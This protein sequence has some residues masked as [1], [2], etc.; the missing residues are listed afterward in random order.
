MG[1]ISPS[2]ETKISKIKSAQKAHRK[3][4]AAF[5]LHVKPKFQ[6]SN[7][8]KKVHRKNGQHF[9]FMWNQN[10]KKNDWAQKTHRKKLA[11]FRLHVKPKFQKSIELKKLIGQ[12]LAAFRL[13]VKPKFQKSNAPP[14][15]LKQVRCLSWKPRFLDDD[16]DVFPP[17]CPAPAP[18]QGTDLWASGQCQGWERVGIRVGLVLGT[19]YP[20]L[21][22]PSPGTIFSGCAKGRGVEEGPTTLD[23]PRPLPR[24]ASSAP[25]APVARRAAP[26]E[27][28][29][30]GGNT[31]DQP[32]TQ[33]PSP[34][35]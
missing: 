30:G 10:F 21:H 20:P 14:K 22:P 1:S 13:H 26:P 8:L 35:T 6:K 17:P 27:G 24:P 12:K 32:T 2:C 19:D 4:W 33:P 28:T 9:A 3:K 34:K 29:E 15:N 5:R 25:R 11:A 23:P 16:A 7:E 18:I 31:R